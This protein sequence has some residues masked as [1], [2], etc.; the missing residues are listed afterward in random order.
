MQ[1]THHIFDSF[2]GLSRPKG[3]DG[4]AWVAGDMRAGVEEVNE[5]LRDFQG[6][7][8]H[9]GWIPSRFAEV[10][11]RVFSFVHIDV[12][13]YEPTLQSIAFFYPKLTQG[14]VLICDDYGFLTC[15]GAT[16]AID[17]FLHDKPEKM[18]HLAGGGGFFVKGCLTAGT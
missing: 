11:D 16:L 14:A 18:I 5:N 10:G 13:L 9:E 17:E 12:D 7:T 6:F 1:R 8:L 3:T 4:A 15:P 2:D